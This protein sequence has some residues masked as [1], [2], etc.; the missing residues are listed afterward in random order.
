M[1]ATTLHQEIKTY[2]IQVKV[3]IQQVLNTTHKGIERILELFPEVQREVREAFEAAMLREETESNMTSHNSGFR[4][5][6]I[7]PKY[8][9]KD[10]DETSSQQSSISHGTRYSNRTRHEFPQQDYTK[11]AEEDE[12]KFLK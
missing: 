12:K 5:P 4:L 7:E 8:L 2:T 3:Q 6:K 11:F 1:V 10:R 9:S